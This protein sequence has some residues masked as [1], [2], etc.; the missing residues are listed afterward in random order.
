M[1]S[2]R[3]AA[4]LGVVLAALGFTVALIVV[5][6]VASGGDEGGAFGSAF[7]PVARDEDRDGRTD[8][9]VGDPTGMTAGG[10]RVHVFHNYHGVAP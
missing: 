8:L 9:V 5:A 4:R 6:V 10:G 2:N 1:S 3:G 7:P